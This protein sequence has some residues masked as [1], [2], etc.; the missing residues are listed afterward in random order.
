MKRIVVFTMGTRGDIQPYI[1]LA[2]ALIKAG[3]EV[4]V[5]THPCWGNL[6]TESG[7]KFIPIGPD[8]DLSLIHI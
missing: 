3:Y 4:T 5:G 8:I 2:Q 7:V 6:V 1:Y